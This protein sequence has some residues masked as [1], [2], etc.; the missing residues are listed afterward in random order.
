MGYGEVNVL[1]WRAK[2]SQKNIFF[3]TLCNT[4]KVQFLIRKI[5]PDKMAKMTFSS[6]NCLTILCPNCQRILY[7][8]FSKEKALTLHYHW[9]NPMPKED[10][11][12]VVR[13][14]RIIRFFVQSLLTIYVVVLKNPNVRVIAYEC[15]SGHRQWL[16][17]LRSKCFVAPN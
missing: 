7:W 17:L 14:L 12:L 16:S 13:C 4:S 11:K 10:K 5:Y 2:T 8:C 6:I 1:S 9:R 3:S 15:V